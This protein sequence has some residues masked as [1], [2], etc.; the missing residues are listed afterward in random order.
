MKSSSR[1]RPRRQ[2]GA[3][4]PCVP[5]PARRN[6]PFAG[7]QTFQSVR[8]AEFYAAD[9]RVNNSGENPRWA[10]RPPACVPPPRRTAPLMVEARMPASEEAELGPNALRLCVVP[11]LRYLFHF[12]Q[13]VVE[14]RA[15]PQPTA[16]RAINAK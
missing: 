16:A 11:Q 1:L 3:G 12:R 4:A 8:P 15:Y 6:R 13:G 10:H 2:N 14:M 9:A 5:L 7:T